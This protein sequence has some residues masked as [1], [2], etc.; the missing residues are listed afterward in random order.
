MKPPS[1]PSRSYGRKRAACLAAVYLLM[2]LHVL[3]WKLA[4]RTLAPLELNEVMYTLELGIVTA[5]FIFMLAAALATLFFGRF[6]CSWG[7]H[8]LALQ[9]LCAWLLER[10]RI[11]PRPIRSRMLLLVPP[12]AMLYM[13]AWPQVSRLL[14]GRPLPILHT[15]VDGQGWASFLTT[16]FWRN[17]PGPWVTLA[18]FAV[19][20]FAIVYVLG[21]RAF[22][23]YGCPYGAVFAIADRFAV[24][25]IVAAGDCTRCGTC[26]SV[27]QS[28]VIVHEEA[29][30]FGRVINPACL[31]DLD[32]VAA[33]PNGAIRY[34]LAR[35]S[36]LDSLR[37]VRV[38]RKPY[39]FS[40][41]EDLLIGLT[42]LACLA[43][44][45]GLYH[46]VP[47]FLTLALGAILGCVL[48]AFLRLFRRS[49]V[50][51]A[52]FQLK[53]GG[54]LTRAGRAFVAGSILAGAVTVQSAA[55]RYH[56]Y[57]GEGLSEEVLHA[58]QI[59]DADQ[60]AMA[61]A[62]LAHLQWCGEWGLLEPVEWPRRRAALRLRLGEHAAAEE[63]LRTVLAT[64][65]G[66][67]AAARDLSAL[68]T[69]RGDAA[70]RAGDLAAALVL[71]GEALHLAPDSAQLHYN[72]A[73]LLAAT[74]RPDHAVDAYRRALALDP[75]DVE[76]MN[77]LALLL[78]GRGDTSGAE[79]LLRGA[80]QAKPDYAPARFNL[81]RILSARGLTVEG[82]MLLRAAVDLDPRF[83]AA[84]REL[85]AATAAPVDAPPS[86]TDASPS[87]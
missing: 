49:H 59:L 21:S 5:G 66:D 56:Q 81:G 79:R 67:A 58:G 1:T 9:D 35:P 20:G 61:R 40:W 37:G 43:I 70:A 29:A 4:G 8:I 57:R 76:S 68:I 25:R 22:C 60:Q 6:F 64:A 31:K 75:R 34:G 16:D 12:L 84:V 13:F 39:D 86:G 72:V 23:A 46:A 77:N 73:V 62:S 83:E 3:H 63:E 74:G 78:A 80:I 7:C 15:R 11:R 17:L 52:D 85:S 45:R 26:T 41:P 38:L 50:R 24:G 14:S 44:F 28:G 55:V 71:F 54:G 10:F 32:C 27:C 2:A 30:R 47:F 53:I 19:C 87:P 48:V 42:V 18:T 51:L 82:Q 33:C 36:I 69:Q 65:P